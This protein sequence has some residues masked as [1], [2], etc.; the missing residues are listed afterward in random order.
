MCTNIII[1]AAAVWPTP[2]THCTHTST[3]RRS[4]GESSGSVA[5]VEAVVCSSAESFCGAVYGGDTRRGERRRRRRRWWWRWPARGHAKA[6]R[7]SRSPVHSTLLPRICSRLRWRR[8]TYSPS[9]A[10]AVATISRARPF[11]RRSI[12]RVAAVS[13]GCVAVVVV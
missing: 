10:T 6:G 3:S 13:R 1:Y 4:L 2:R 12:W 7:Q 8:T 5:Q 9:P 11:A